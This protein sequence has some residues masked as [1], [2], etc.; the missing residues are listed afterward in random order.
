MKRKLEQEGG[1]KKKVE[2]ESEDEVKEGIQERTSKKW[3]AGKRVGDWYHGKQKTTEERKKNLSGIK[4]QEIAE[5]KAEIP[6]SCKQS[7][8]FTVKQWVK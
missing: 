7:S 6:V 1:L 3:G 5:M 2:G 4:A 8:Q